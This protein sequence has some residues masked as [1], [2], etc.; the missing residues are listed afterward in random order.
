MMFLQLAQ[1]YLC[2]FVLFSGDFYTL[3]CAIYRCS[4]VPA[5]FVLCQWY[6]L[7]IALTCKYNENNWNDINCWLVLQST[8]GGVSTVVI[9]F[10]K[11]QCS[12]GKV[13]R[14]STPSYVTCRTQCDA[15]R[16]CWYWNSGNSAVKVWMLYEVQCCY[17][18]SNRN[19]DKTQIILQLNG[20][21]W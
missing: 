21:Y 20:A 19:L 6:L 7:F 9:D 3:F 11:M 15:A 2:D 16:W 17:F 13:Q 4:A 18:F 12:V 5:L 1:F 8:P 14:L 10:D